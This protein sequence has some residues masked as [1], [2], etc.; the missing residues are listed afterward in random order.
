MAGHAGLAVSR[1]ES[2][3]LCGP[4][5]ES[6]TPRVVPFLDVARVRRDSRE[7]NNNRPFSALLPAD[8]V[9]FGVFADRSVFK[10]G[11]YRLLTGTVASKV[12]TIRDITMSIYR[13]HLI[14]DALHVHVFPF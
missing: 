4:K 3:V 14:V 13:T 10:R 12:N 9:C 11:T 6:G 1:R 2:R 5:Y 7:H 8:R